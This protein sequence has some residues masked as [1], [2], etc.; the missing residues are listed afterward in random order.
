LKK[1]YLTS[2]SDSKNKQEI[3]VSTSSKIQELL[4]SMAEKRKGKLTEEK[5][6]LLDGH[7]ISMKDLPKPDLSI[8]KR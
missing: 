8:L 2:Y 7:M 1:E 6:I 3:F 4:H 5:S